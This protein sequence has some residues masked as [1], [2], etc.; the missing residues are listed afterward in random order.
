[1][2]THSFPFAVDYESLRYRGAISSVGV[3]VSD[4]VLGTRWSG[5][6]VCT[7]TFRYS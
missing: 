1:M 6:V 5:L 2:A 3:S 4:G 7:R